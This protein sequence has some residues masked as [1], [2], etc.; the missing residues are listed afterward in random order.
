[1]L[2]KNKILVLDHGS[3]DSKELE[4]I[5]IKA[6]PEIKI[7]QNVENDP[8]KIIEVAK[9][10]EII[11]TSSR[12]NFSEEVLEALGD[13]KFLTTLSTGFNHI[14]TKFAKE[15]NIKVANVTGYSTSSVAQTTFSLLLELLLEAQKHSQLIKKGAWNNAGLRFFWK[16]PLHELKGKT[17]GIIGFGNIGRKVAQIAKAFEMKVIAL[18]RNYPKHEFVNFTD[19][20]NL[21]G[22]SD[23]VSL[24]APLNSET[25]D[26]INTETLKKM[27]KT[28]YLIN[29]A[30]G[31]LVVEGDLTQ[32][33]NEGQIAGAG[34]DVLKSEPPNLDNPLLKAKNVVITPHIGWVSVEARRKLI[35]ET[36]KNIKSF[37]VGEDRNLV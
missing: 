7:K 26:L 22:Q 33:L 21:L 6:F 23:F 8:R 15:R 3:I 17:L 20:D 9:G 25:K 32:A 12:L 13:L 34:L 35:E 19:L 4:D 14:D 29:T 28:A 36:V 1:M 16:K 37:F 2:M 24:H 27:K 5:L 30:R 31:G 18:R 11:V 10:Y